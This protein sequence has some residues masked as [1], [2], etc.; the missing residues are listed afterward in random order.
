MDYFLQSGESIVPFMTSS[1]SRTFP[2]GIS[3]IA[4]A[5]SLPPCFPLKMEHDL[6]AEVAVQ[7]KTRRAK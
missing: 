6:T 2:G 7:T 1:V 5:S 4:A 3:T